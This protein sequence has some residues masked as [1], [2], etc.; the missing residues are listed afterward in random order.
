[1]NFKFIGVFK[2][3]KKSGGEYYTITL[4]DEMGNAPQVFVTEEQA[5][6]LDSVKP[7]TDI[8]ENIKLS[9]KQDINGYQLYFN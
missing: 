1:M 6:Y 4:L 7:M 5:K 3:P 8:T 2:H 9:Y